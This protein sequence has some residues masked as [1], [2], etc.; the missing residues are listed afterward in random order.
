MLSPVKA[1]TAGAL[2]FAIGGAFLIA[3]PF[4][5]AASVPG[6]EAPA[7][8]PTWVT[9]TGYWAPSCTGPESTEVDGDVTRERGR[10]CEPTRYEMSDSRLSGEASWRWNTDMYQTADGQ[11][12]VL[13]G[14]EYIRNDG[15]GWTCP[16]LRLTTAGD[17][18]SQFNS[19]DVMHC[20]GDGGYAGL[21]ALIVSK[22]GSS[23]NIQALIF[24]G[25]LPPLPGPP[26]AESNASAE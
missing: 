5:Q 11:R 3:Q 7:V 13:Y 1:I 23:G 26:P 18:L 12:A 22:T 14:A 21:S 4:Q 8:E 17:S 9:G 10:V 16:V 20:V 2:V 19:D 25:D 15:G 24:S 6:A